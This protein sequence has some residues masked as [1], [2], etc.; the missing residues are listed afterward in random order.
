MLKALLRASLVTLTFTGGLQAQT[1]RDLP[2]LVDAAWLADNLDVPE[3]VVIHVGSTGD[4]TGAER[5]PGAHSLPLQR[6]T[7][8]GPNGTFELPPPLEL[9]IALREVAVR[10]DAYV[11]FY[12]EPRAAARAW[13]TLD[14]LGIADRAAILDGGLDAW[15]AGGHPTSGAEPG[16]RTGSFALWPQTERIVSAPWVSER[17]GN[18]DFILLDA[19]GDAEYT[20]SD[21]GGATRAGRIPGAR[22]LS[23]EH[24]LVDGRMRPE[25]EIRDLFLAA[26]AEPGRTLVVYCSDGARSPVVYFAARML[27]YPVRLY[28]GSWEDWSVRDLPLESGPATR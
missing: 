24:L 18:P 23:W 3:L 7:R 5:I 19:R 6:I 28:D 13:L 25:A 21:A 10:D 22:H 17:L 20:G 1:P 14:Y 16:S 9:L 12:G 2:M 11:V 26:G 15:R 27:G 4:E 8:E